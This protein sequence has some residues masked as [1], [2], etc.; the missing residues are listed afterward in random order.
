[1]SSILPTP[2]DCCTPC[3]P[4]QIVDLPSGGGGS[5]INFY[6]YIDLLR[7]ETRVTV[8]VDD[9]PAMVYGLNAR[10]DGLGGGFFFYNA[11]NNLPDDGVSNII[12]NSVIRPALGGWEKWLG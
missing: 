6:D 1:L 4:I 2:S 10:N 11:T 8:L 9:M 12:P 7:Q 5:G 3:C